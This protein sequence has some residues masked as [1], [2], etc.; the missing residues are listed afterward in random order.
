MVLLPEQVTQVKEAD[1]F[2]VVRADEQPVQIQGAPLS[3]PLDDGSLP[4]IELQRIS[5]AH[6][7]CW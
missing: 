6:E 5:E 4:A 2:G 1:L 7:D 3:L